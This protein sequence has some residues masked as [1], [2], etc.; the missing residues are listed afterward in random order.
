MR[1][2]GK[3]WI[4]AAAERLEGADPGANRRVKG[5]RLVTAFALATMA[6][7]L[8]ELGGSN[9]LSLLAGGIALWASVYEARTPRID[10]S[11]D[12]LLLCLAGA[13]GATSYALAAPTLDDLGPWGPELAF[14]FGAFLTGYLRRFGLLGTGIG[15]QIFIGQVLASTTNLG[16]EN[17]PTIAT[18]GIIAMIAAVVPRLLSGPSELPATALPTP[19]V[20]ACGPLELSPELAMG[21]QAATAAIVVLWVTARFQLTEPVWG[22]TAATYVIAGSS[23]GTMDRVRRRILG[24]SIGVPIGLACLPLANSAPLALWVAAALALIVYAMAL[25]ERYDVASGAY[26]FALIVTLAAAGEH[27]LP[28]LFARSWETV[29]GA[30]LGL[31]S[32]FAVFPLRVVSV[33]TPS[34]SSPQL[35][36]RSDR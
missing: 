7:R 11:R 6:G 9:S 29:L 28:M 13:L 30:A 1:I 14:V 17:L 15:S 8:P 32:A 31:A 21:L 2:E 35:T 3:R 20:R 34:P 18:A 36:G 27:E 26:A 5:L 33:D 12:L 19:A 16:P 22:I 23:A 25:P 10:S 24:T 4:E